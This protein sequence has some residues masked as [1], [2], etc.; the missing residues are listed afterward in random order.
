[1]NLEVARKIQLDYYSKEFAAYGEDIR[2][3][4]YTS[5]EAQ[6]TR[7]QAVSEIVDFN[8][9][10]MLD[11][12]CGF[13]DLYAF[14]EKQG[15]YPRKYVGIDINPKMIA[16]ARRR[17]P[18]LKFEVRD[19]MDGELKD[20]FDLVVALGLFGL[21]MP[22]WQDVVERQLSKMYGLC[23][24]GLVVNF[25]SYYTVWG[26]TANS[27]Y[28]RPEDILKFVLNNLSN[29]VIMRHDYRLSDFTVYVYRGEVGT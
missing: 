1:M 12:G 14:L 4:G 20:K 27:H 19:I 22:H 15:V 16:V 5:A 25:L 17:F 26:K 2:S 21:E 23:E 10:S 29:R 11:V 13:G 9:K 8:N 18:Q 6:E 3:L 28:A 24:I 7:M